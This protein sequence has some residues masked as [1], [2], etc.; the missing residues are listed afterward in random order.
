MNPLLMIAIVVCIV[1]FGSKPFLRRLGI[2]LMTGAKIAVA[3][4]L[5]ALLSQCVV[6]VR[7]LE[8]SDCRPG[9]KY[10]AELDVCEGAVISQ[11]DLT[12]VLLSLPDNASDEDISKA[13]AEHQTPT[14]LDR[15][16]SQVLDW[17]RRR[18]QP[19]AK[20]PEPVAQKT[21]IALSPPIS[22][23]GL[24]DNIHG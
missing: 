11:K 22:L 1:A 6:W 5:V 9:Q 13:V 15:L 4:V 2:L 23:Q 14:R 7:T 3:A 20:R 12:E 10:V 8:M 18:K 16:W 24:H 17:N 21:P 19:V